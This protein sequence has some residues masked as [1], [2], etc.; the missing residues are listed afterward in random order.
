[1][2][3]KSSLMFARSL[4][5]PKTEKK[6]SARRSLFGAFICIGLSIVPLVVVLSVASGMIDGMTER[7]I[8]LSS[9]HLQAYVASN[10][11]QVKSADSFKAF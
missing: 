3:I 8:G 6:S 10:I 1:M 5:F 4:I 2:T 9:N 7:I 11:L